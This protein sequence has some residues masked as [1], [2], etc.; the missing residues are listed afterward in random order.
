MFWK[1]KLYSWWFGVIS[2][3]RDTCHKLTLGSVCILQELGGQQREQCL[4]KRI[5]LSWRFR[6]L[7]RWNT[8]ILHNSYSQAGGV[9]GIRFFSKD[10][11]CQDTWQRCDSKSLW[12]NRLPSLD[13]REKY[14][15]PPKVTYCP[16][17]AV[18]CAQ[19]LAATQNTCIIWLNNTTSSQYSSLENEGDLFQTII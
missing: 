17:K 2:L 6:F 18:Q 11:S 15:T 9:S 3:R 14:C 10:F 1:V 5:L 8:S 7:V 4:H 13:P 19:S 12:I 16:S